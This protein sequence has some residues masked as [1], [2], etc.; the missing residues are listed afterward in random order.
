MTSRHVPYD[1]SFYSHRY[2]MSSISLHTHTPCT[3]THIHTRTHTHARR[4]THADTHTHTHARTRTRMHT[5]THA[6]THTHTHTSFSHSLMSDS[7][8]QHVHGPLKVSKSISPVF[9]CICSSPYLALNVVA[10]V[11][12]TKD[13][14]RLLRIQRELHLAKSIVLCFGLTCSW[15]SRTA[16]GSDCTLRRERRCPW[17]QLHFRI[18]LQLS[19]CR[20]RQNSLRCT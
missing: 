13:T 20:T 2:V 14:D 11:K 4:H 19:S 17:S 10:S 8:C 16:E 6:C 1:N 3:Y 12:T 9:K 5:R 15:T 7:N 18:L